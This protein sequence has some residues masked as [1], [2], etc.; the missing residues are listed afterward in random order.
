MKKV[1][2]NILAEGEATG[3]FHQA[4]GTGVSVFDREDGVRVL[5]APEGATIT[6]QEHGVVV[7]PPGEYERFIVVEADP[8]SEEIRAVRD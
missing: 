6:H 7:L 2:N 3:H 8:F 5:N 4:V 1:K